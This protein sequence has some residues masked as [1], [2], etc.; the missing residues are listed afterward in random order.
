LQIWLDHAGVFRACPVPEYTTI[1]DNFGV[2][3]R[4]PHVPVHVH[5]GDDVMAPVG[6][7]ILAPFDGYASTGRS[8]LGGLEVRVFGADGYI[9][10]A[11]LSALGTLGYVSAG[12]VVGYVGATGDA[13]GPH[14]HVEWHPGDGA[15]VDP[16]A[17][18]T[19]ACV[20]AINGS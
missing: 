18:L 3:V 14:D 7:P 20:D 2:I 8:K 13:T 10:N 12:D 4:L 11:H 9:Y 5:Q 16:N 19:A 6:S 1:Y 17:L 15:A